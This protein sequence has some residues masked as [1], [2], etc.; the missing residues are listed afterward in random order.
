MK[1]NS[2][3]PRPASAPPRRLPSGFTL[4]ELMIT[5]VVL[6]IVMV[7][8]GAVMM[9]ASHSKLSTSNLAESSQ[10]ARV[11]TDLIARDL[12]SAGYG[13]DLA[14]T[15][16][17]Q[18]SIS[19]VDSLQVL[20]NENVSPW[21]DSSTNAL[22]VPMHKTPLAFKPGVGNQPRPL[23]GTAWTPPIKYRTGAETVR[24]T[25]DLNNDGLVNASD[26]NDPNGI[27]AARTPNPNDY[28]LVRQVYGDSTNNVPNNN[29]PLTQR[30][31]IVSA[32]GGGVPPLFTV[33]MRGATQ[34]W[35]WSTGPVPPES[36][37]NIARVV[38]KATAPSP[39][40]DARGNYVA[41]T[42]TTT[43]T[44][45]RNV[46]DLGPPEYGVDGYVF[47]DLN[48]NGTFDA[49]EQGIAGA[50]VT[51]GPYATTT[52]VSGYFLL[53]APTGTYTLRHSPPA[54][55]AVETN[56]DSFV[57]TVPPA[58]SK[59]FADTSIAGGW[60]TSHCFNDLNGNLVQDFGEPD[61]GSVK[62]V[63]DFHNQI[64][65]TPSNGRVVQFAGVGSYTVTATPPDSFVVESANPVTK[66]MVASVNDSI[67]FAC[68]QALTGTVQGTVYRDN[69]KNGSYDSGESGIA[70]VWVGVSKDGGITVQGF[71][72]TDAS[73]NYSIPKVPIN[74]PPHTVPYSIMVIP[75]PGFFPTS[76]TAIPNV[77][78]QF[79]QTLTGYNFGMSSFQIISLNASRVLS[80]ASGDLQEKDYNGNASNAHLDA[81]LVL[82]SDTGGT[83]QISVWFNQWNAASL[84]NATPT[85]TRS[86][87]NAV[88]GMVLDTLDRSPPASQPDLVTGTKATAS[89]NFFIWFNQSTNGN[90]GYFPLTYSP[91][92][93][94]KTNDNG[95]VQAVLSYDCAGNATPDQPDIIVG[96]ASPTAG[97]GTVEIWKNSNANNNPIF[98]REEIY[99]PAGLT[100]ANMGEVTCMALADLDG[101]G[102]RDLVV[103]TKTGLYSGQVM[104]FHFA[105][106]IALPHFTYAGSIGFPNDIVTNLAMVDVDGDGGKDLIAG[107]M[108]STN[109][110]K[111]YY[112]H[113]K[114][115]TPSIYDF[116]LYR[117]VDAP[118]IVT[119]MVAADFG[120]SSRGDLAVGFRTS[121]VGF[122]GG[123]RIYFLDSGT[124]PSNGTDPS[125]GS[126][127]NWVP[128]LNANNFNFG[129]NPVPAGPYLTDLA[130]GVKTSA[131]TGALVVFIR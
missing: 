108:N 110:G 34:P 12:R 40:P 68:V 47:N 7:A 57:V 111:L 41:T 71:S 120:G 114:T 39:R 90:E 28:E 51:L 99:P 123:F 36:L 80:L 23:L 5:L 45:M 37:A 18:P 22:G 1:M 87:P 49:G 126:I 30:V 46:P 75:P 102:N 6:G 106:R 59:S 42:F 72:Y 44:S 89:G 48:K 119:S 32:P 31:A 88:M 69:N 24:W 53:P 64:N 25:L 56:P 35:D 93:N 73:G 65:W 54:N 127:T 112:Y 118:G 115:Q 20:I 82:G 62:I 84:F 98:T 66:T 55:F 11:A 14:Y 130:V 16:A 61:L 95:D 58:T 70:N 94:Y 67:T 43:V 116:Q 38:V 125:A 74:D 19:Y 78:L 124:L 26:L 122:G 103:G 52:G 107:T 83:D 21:P 97:Q 17:P 10:S 113:N 104:F 76:T 9:A 117:T 129:A 33:Y 96:T 91:G 13:A 121:S 2:F 50:R 4:I 92:Q 86:A 63:M 105:S 131:S 85:Y 81:D 79:N 27:D 128:A 29:G 77:W 109:S 8:L 60:V 100:P 15:P 3:H 101:D